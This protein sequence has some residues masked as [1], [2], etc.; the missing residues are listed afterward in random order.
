VG[1][2]LTDM[3][4]V[5]YLYHY[6]ELRNNDIWVNYVAGIQTEYRNKREAAD[7]QL[8]LGQL[9]HQGS[10]R[11]YLMEFRALNNFT[12]ATGEVLKE[13]VDL[14]MTSEILRMCDTGV[15]S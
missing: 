9:R 13:K 11:A 1:T 6:R 8:K 3:A 15:V 10:I 14:A 2:L 5:W 7:A 12:R 4:L